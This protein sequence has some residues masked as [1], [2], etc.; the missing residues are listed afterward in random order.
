[1]LQ[2]LDQSVGNFTCYLNMDTGSSADLFEDIIENTADVTNSFD[3][4]FGVGG[5]TS[6][7][8]RVELH[9]ET[10]HLEVPTHSL[11]DVISLEVNFHGLPSTILN[12]P[13]EAD[14]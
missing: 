10:C 14:Y 1:M 6:S 12:T 13:D 2:V 8:S 4:T 7:T 9:M 3:L 11:D 5:T